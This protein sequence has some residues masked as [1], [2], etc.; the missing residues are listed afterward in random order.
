M[1]GRDCSLWAH[2]NSNVHVSF[3]R[4]PGVLRLGPP[5]SV[6]KPELTA[7]TSENDVSW[8]ALPVSVLGSV[9]RVPLSSLY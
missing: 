1:S 3:P 7:F 5:G 2:S 6:G 8:E 4:M 9:P